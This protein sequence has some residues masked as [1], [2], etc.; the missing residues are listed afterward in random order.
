[1]D[2]VKILQYALSLCEVDGLLLLVFVAGLKPFLAVAG[3]DL[4]K[5]RGYG[6][7]GI[8]EILKG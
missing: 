7:L 4:C 6:K 1:V 3:K 2:I 8:E 5:R